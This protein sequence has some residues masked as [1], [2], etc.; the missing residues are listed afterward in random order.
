[1]KIIEGGFMCRP[2][3]VKLAQTN[4]DFR[5]FLGKLL[6]IFSMGGGGGGSYN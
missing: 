5:T 6:G 2:P 4:W 3:K 1:M